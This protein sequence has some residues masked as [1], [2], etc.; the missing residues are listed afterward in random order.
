VYDEGKPRAVH[1]VLV[2][3]NNESFTGAAIPVYKMT[4][5]GN[6]FPVWK[7]GYG[8][9][10]LSKDSAGLYHFHSRFD[11]QW[12]GMVW[13][14]EFPAIIYTLVF[15]SNNSMAMSGEDERLIADQQLQPHIVPEKE[16]FHKQGLV[17][18]TDLSPAFWLIAFVLFL[19]ERILASRKKKEAAY[20]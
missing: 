12:N 15:G 8:D 5:H 20:G 1:S 3:G 6:G 18:Q 14:E 9:A 19:L 10:L 7:N 13:N 17:Q 2:P 4:G 11:P 16:M